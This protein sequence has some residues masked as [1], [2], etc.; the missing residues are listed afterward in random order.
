MNCMRVCSLV[1][2]WGTVS[3]GILEFVRA[4]KAGETDEADE[5]PEP[6]KTTV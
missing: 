2:P 5:H 6:V 3:S 1:W 4:R